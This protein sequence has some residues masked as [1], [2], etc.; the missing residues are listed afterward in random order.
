MCAC[1]QIR[2]SL[3]VD[4]ACVECVPHMVVHT[5][6]AKDV[7]PYQ[8]LEVDKPVENVADFGLRGQACVVITGVIL[9]VERR[10]DRVNATHTGNQRR[11]LIED[12]V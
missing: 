1:T 3:F 2:Q 8:A 6:N 10:L 5:V 7:D 12:Q 11:N 9:G 4:A